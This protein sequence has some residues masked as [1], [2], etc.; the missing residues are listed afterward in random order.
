MHGNAMK[1]VPVAAQTS[2]PPPKEKG[3]IATIID[4]A[5]GRAADT[6]ATKAVSSGKEQI[7]HEIETVKQET[8]KKV[9]NKA[10]E[11]VSGDK[12]K[13]L[14]LGA[15][16]MSAL[17]LGLEIWNRHTGSKTNQSAPTVVNV[18]YSQPPRQ[19]TSAPKAVRK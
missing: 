3:W 12:S 14:I 19:I 1:P 5:V 17:S 16:V 18:Y 9:D 11:L 2:G 6:A 10:E 8:M 13:Y 7:A 15:F 4:A